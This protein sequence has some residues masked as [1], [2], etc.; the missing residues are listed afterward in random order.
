MSAERPSKAVARKFN[1]ST[2]RTRKPDA[3]TLVCDL[4][5]EFCS[6]EFIE[7]CLISG[8]QI[9]YLPPRQPLARRPYHKAQVERLLADLNRQLTR[10]L[11]STR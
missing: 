11:S 9:A 1:K 3:V 8:F 4:G 10:P 5:Q 6:R 7:A 2:L